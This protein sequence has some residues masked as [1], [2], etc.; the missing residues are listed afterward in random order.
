M[1]TTQ[2]NLA[3]ARN[4]IDPSNREAMLAGLA[5]KLAKIMSEIG[6]VAK[7]GRNEFHKYDYAT[8][9]DIVVA[10]RD[11]LAEHNVMLFPSATEIRREGTLTTAIFEFAFV[12]GDTGATWSSLW[13]GT[14][15]DKGDKGL[16]KAYTGALKYFLSKTFQIPTGDDPEATEEGQSA[17]RPRREKKAATE[18][19]E[20]G[21]AS[22]TEAPSPAEGER[23]PDP[24]E[25]A[26]TD[27][28][29]E[30]VERNKARA[31]LFAVLRARL[32][33]S[34][35]AI[36][37]DGKWHPVTAD[38]LGNS[39]KARDARHGLLEFAL[40]RKIESTNDLAVAE[41]QTVIGAVEKG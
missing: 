17:A 4:V 12:D 16:Y 5:S 34:E 30:Q 8:E 6:Y 18:G 14:G 7:R 13:A 41:W 28:Q 40:G 20:L 22:A 37:R 27:E 11:K 19:R 25:A 24:S 31:K 1:T 2:E 9:A 39:D 32:Q 3:P 23:T 38:M 21:A 29:K 35:F 26:W 33:L 15:E 36:N 10:V